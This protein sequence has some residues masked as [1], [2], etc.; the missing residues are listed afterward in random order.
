MATTMTRTRGTVSRDRFMI[1]VMGGIGAV[2]ALFYLGTI[3]RFLYPKNAGATPPLKLKLS[4]DG[5]TEPR[6]GSYHAFKKGVAGPVFYPMTEDRSVVV[7]IFVEKKDAAGALTAGNLRVAE[8][9]CTHLGCPVAWVALDNLYECP[10]HGSEFNRDLSV[11]H[12]PALK[13]LMEH[14]FTLDGDALTIRERTA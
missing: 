13:P 9:T 14:K 6:S 10:C 3:V 7:G 8:Q 12:G 2:I 5:V 4:A 1:G 11:H